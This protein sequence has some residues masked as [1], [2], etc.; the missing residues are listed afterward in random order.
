[1]REGSVQITGTAFAMSWCASLRYR[2][3]GE[4]DWGETLSQITKT[5]AKVLA[6]CAKAA[7]EVLNEDSL[8]RNLVHE[9]SAR[10]A[11]VLF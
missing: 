7:L 8:S 6:L 4:H 11:L 2:A 9:L 5:R 1:L 3:V 10:T